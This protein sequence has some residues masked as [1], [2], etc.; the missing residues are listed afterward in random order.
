MNDPTSAIIPGSKFDTEIIVVDEDAPPKKF[1]MRLQPVFI[2]VHIF[3][4]NH[5]W[6]KMGLRMIP[7]M[8]IFAQPMQHVLAMHSVFS[9]TAIASKQHRK[10]ALSIGERIQQ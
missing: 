8:P 7:T 6:M 2:L 3:L 10:V 9:V 5:N 4:S 1:K